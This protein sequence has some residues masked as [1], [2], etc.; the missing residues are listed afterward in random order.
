MA[1]A[2]ALKVATAVALKV[3]TACTHQHGHPDSLVMPTRTPKLPR[4][5]STVHPDCLVT[6]AQCTQTAS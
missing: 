1:T 6:P 5:A 2:V 4:D 3:A